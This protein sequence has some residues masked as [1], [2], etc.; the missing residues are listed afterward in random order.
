MVRELPRADVQGPATG[1]HRIMA[2]QQGLRAW[3]FGWTRWSERWY[4]AYALLGATSVGLM[5]ILLPL[6]VGRA[7]GAAGVGLVMA[8]VNL[9]GLTAPLWGALADRFRLHRALLGGGLS[10]TAASLAAFTPVTTLSAR[11]GLALV[12]G[13]GIAAA[14]TVGNLFVVERHPQAEW[15]ER[16]GWLQ[17]FYGAGQVAGLLLAVAFVRTSLG[18][19]LI[20]GAGL[21]ALAGVLGTMTAR[22][23]PARV[24]DR[25]VTR[26]T[27][28]HAEPFHLSPQH[29]FH[30]V[31]LA[32]LRTLRR[33]LIS[34]FGIFLAIW[35]IS[36]AGSTAFF[37][38][39]PVLMQRVY[40]ASPSVSS[41]A[42]ALAAALGLGLYSPAGRWSERLGPA[43]VLRSGLALRTLAFAAL[44]ALAFATVAG[45]G[46]GAL[47]GFVLVVL[48]WSLLTVSGTSLA[49]LLSPVGEGAGLGIYSATSSLAG[50]T[51]ALL[52]GAI[53]GGWGYRA[54]PIT[55][56]VALGL[57]LLVVITAGRAFAALGAPVPAENRRK[58]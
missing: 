22:T 37:S 24:A 1:Y 46:W 5:P 7:G 32:D 18:A 2:Q 36:L 30:Y 9:G 57:G 43:R 29:P 6:E 10:L 19:G 35:L 51:G 27:S 20:T 55:S 31:N 47:A 17:T 39:Y 44:A 25:P 56:A 12:Q 3:A 58:T 21:V 49:A 54:V 53:A 15:D 34:P 40:A 11:V 28:R 48:A 13:A 41:V 42:F 45:R 38:L 52:G 33:Q 26:A 16:I 8:S 4:L 14:S 23:A 50:V